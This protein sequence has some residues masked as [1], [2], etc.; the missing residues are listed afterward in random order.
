MYDSDPIFSFLVALAIGVSSYKGFNDKEYEAK[1]IFST[2]HILSYKQYYRLLTS[3]LLHGGFGHLLFNMYS[4]VSFSA[5]LEFHI[6]PM[7]PVI[8][9][10]LG[11]IFGGFISL[12]I[13]KQHEYY[14]YGAS[15]GVCAVIYASIFLFPGGRISMLFLP[16]S[17]PSYLF[18][19]LYL[20]YSAYASAKAQD[21]IGHEA[22]LG[23]AICGTAFAAIFDP[24]TIF[25]SLPLYLTVI[26]VSYVYFY[27]MFNK[28]HYSLVG[29]DLSEVF[30][31][32]KRKCYSRKGTVQE[33]EQLN[34]LLEI[35][36]IVGF[37]NLPKSDQDKL[38][39]LS[40]IFKKEMISIKKGKDDY[41]RQRGG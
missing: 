33:K 34:S 31:E 38:R 19:F 24:E 9:L 18:A 36:S 8:I 28:L 32:L 15:G 2:K 41:Y 37:E 12:L 4:F 20:L 21:N 17:I 35:V 1:L 22:H 14:A 40:A 13:H 39:K 27:V 6:S 23:G 25:E 26:A 30:N 7:L 5:R 10:I 11:I 29:K 3:G 16:I